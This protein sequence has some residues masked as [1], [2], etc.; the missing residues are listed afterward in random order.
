M[1]KRNF[2]ALGGTSCC[3]DRQRS[4]LIFQSEVIMQELSKAEIEEVSGGVYML[5]PVTIALLAESATWGPIGFAFGAGYAAGT[6]L[7]NRYLSK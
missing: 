1:I 3:S 2:V 4:L 7:Y 6:L 5:A